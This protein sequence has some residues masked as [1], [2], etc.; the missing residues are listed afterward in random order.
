[1]RRVIGLIVLS[2]LLTA[3][4]HGP[5]TDMHDTKSW[6]NYKCQAAGDGK[7]YEGWSTTKA[8]ARRNAMA[9]CSER[10]SNCQLVTCNDALP[11]EDAMPAASDVN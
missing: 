10:A 7:T 2:L 3:C 1:M 5:Q 9:I 8:A 6:G 4:A 11:S